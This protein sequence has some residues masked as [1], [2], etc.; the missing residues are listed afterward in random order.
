MMIFAF[1]T[2]FIVILSVLANYKVS[3]VK[4][5]PFWLNAV[6]LLIIAAPT[7]LIFGAPN[8]G[9]RLNT[10][11]QIIS[12]NDMAFTSFEGL[13]SKD[14]KDSEAWQDVAVMLR[15]QGS[16]PKAAQAFERAGDHAKTTQ[17]K[18][19]FYETAGFM[20]IEASQG[21]VDREAYLMFTKALESDPK[22]VD[23]QFYLGVSNQSA[24]QAEIA[25]IHYRTFLDIADPRHPLIPEVKDRIEHLSNRRPNSPSINNLP[26]LSQSMIEDFKKLPDDER[27]VFIQSMTLRRLAQL[28][29][30]GGTAEEWNALAK[31]F[32]IAGDSE[33]AV[34]ARQ[35]AEKLSP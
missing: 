20:Q 3:K 1:I 18:A 6:A 8:Y 32:D 21:L 19:R 16:Y 33:K 28:E 29:E 10:S 7:Y 27:K 34:Y 30:G 15:L 26:V 11:S 9:K 12:S 24:G 31:I 22:T 23:A 35:K 17:D 14:S 4:S 13:I 2:L 25:L 5:A